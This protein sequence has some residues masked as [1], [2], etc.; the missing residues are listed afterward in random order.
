M[1]ST[2]LPQQA[3][4]QAVP[5]ISPFIQLQ[6]RLSQKIRNSF[7]VIKTQAIPSAFAKPFQSKAGFSINKPGGFRDSPSFKNS[8]SEIRETINNWSFEVQRFNKL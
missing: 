1:W 7:R 3:H 4:I 6:K 5:S 2:P 8:F